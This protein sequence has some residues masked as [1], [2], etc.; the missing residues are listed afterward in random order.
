MH[1][2]LLVKNSVKFETH[3]CLSS[4][5]EKHWYKSLRCSAEDMRLSLL[6][7]DVVWLPAG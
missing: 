7:E 4:L 6:N 2:A 1:I 3:K 5:Q